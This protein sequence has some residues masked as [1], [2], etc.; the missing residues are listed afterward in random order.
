MEKKELVV[1]IVIIL[2]LA[3]VLIISGVFYFSLV[4]NE[5]SMT[6]RVVQEEQFNPMDG[7][8]SQNTDVPDG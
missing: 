5:F 8:P 2:V 4:F 3:A 1:V 6:G 7:E